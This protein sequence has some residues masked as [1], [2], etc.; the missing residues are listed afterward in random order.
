MPQKP[1]PGGSVFEPRSR[2]SPAESFG[3]VSIRLPAS[4]AEDAQFEAAQFQHLIANAVRE[5]VLIRHKSLRG[6]VHA[7]S[8]QSATAHERPTLSDQPT[9]TY[10]RLSRIQRGETMMT[11]TDLVLWCKHFDDVAALA[12]KLLEPDR[13]NQA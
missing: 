5:S 4:G 6:F 13:T 10:E 3:K 1:K 7:L 12:A 9:M 11:L 2:L 8:G